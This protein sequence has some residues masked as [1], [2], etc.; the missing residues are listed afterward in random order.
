M[1]QENPFKNRA[2]PAVP[3][4]PVEIHILKRWSASDLLA[5]DQ[6][7]PP[8]IRLTV[9]SAKP[10]GPATYGCWVLDRRLLLLSFRDRKSHGTVKEAERHHHGPGP[11]ADRELLTTRHEP[12]SFSRLRRHQGIF[13]RQASRLRRLPTRPMQAHVR[14]RLGR[15]GS[16]PVHT[17]KT[18]VWCKDAKRGPV[19]RQGRSRETPLRDPWRPEHR[20]KNSHRPRSHCRCPASSV[21]KGQGELSFEPHQAPSTGHLPG[22]CVAGPSVYPDPKLV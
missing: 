3:P 7:S 22:N 1:G 11:R 10:Q 16:P 14:N 4:V 17:R 8:D 18:Q 15:S 6:V 9:F 21:G 12:G 5:Q 20:P 2:V 13:G 19:R